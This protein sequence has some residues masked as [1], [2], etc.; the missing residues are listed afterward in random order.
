MESVFYILT[1][2]MIPSLMENNSLEI[3]KRLLCLVWF[4]KCERLK[5]FSV[6]DINPSNISQEKR[7]PTCR[8]DFVL[9]LGT[10]WSDAPP[11]EATR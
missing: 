5:S 8:P 2:Y 4:S 9:Y 3:D 6:R 10:I 11:T 1:K 7:R